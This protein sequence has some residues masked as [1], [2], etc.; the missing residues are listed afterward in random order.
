MNE[1]TN[2]ASLVTLPG[3]MIAVLMI[4]QYTKSWLPEKF[5]T[6]LYVLIWSLVITQGAAFILGWSWQDHILMIINGGAVA[7]GA[8]GSYEQTFKKSDTIKKTIMRGPII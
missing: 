4:V 1:F 3:A 5:D 6:K 7:F 2:W 8:F